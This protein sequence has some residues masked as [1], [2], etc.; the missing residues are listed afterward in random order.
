MDECKPLV[1]GAAAAATPTPTGKHSAY[2]FSRAAED[3][4][5][6][7]EPVWPPVVDSHGR[8]V[9]VDPIKPTLKAPGTKHLKLKRG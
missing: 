3:L 1:A 4:G 8:T 7:G 6:G 5:A 2:T 9:Q